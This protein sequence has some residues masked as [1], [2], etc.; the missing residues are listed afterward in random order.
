[1]HKQ[2]IFKNHHQLHLDLNLEH[3]DGS[4]VPGTMSRITL[5]QEKNAQH[6]NGVGQMAD[7]LLQETTDFKYHQIQL[8]KNIG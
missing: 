8:Y 4:G 3:V 7:V 5:L 6:G 2:F 1:M